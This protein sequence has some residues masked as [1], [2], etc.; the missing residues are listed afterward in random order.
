MY[1]EIGDTVQYYPGGDRTQPPWCA[2]VTRL[3]NGSALTLN[4]VCP[5][6]RNMDIFEGV[7]C[8]GDKA[9]K[10]VEIREMGGWAPL[11]ITVALRELLIASNALVWN[12]EDRLVPKAEY[13]P[14]KKVEK[15]EKPVKPPV[16]PLVPSA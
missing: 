11:P 12:D 10:A 4:T 9:V 5:D 13:V 1:A 14:K 15:T 7:R 8:L 2:L 6:L 16:P 3:G